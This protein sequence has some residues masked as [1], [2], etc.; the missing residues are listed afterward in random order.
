MKKFTITYV[1]QDFFSQGFRKHTRE[2]WGAVNA[3]RV[4]GEIRSMR[5][6]PVVL[7]VTCE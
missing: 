6:A 2:V 7:W 5:N 1:A 4:L 3:H